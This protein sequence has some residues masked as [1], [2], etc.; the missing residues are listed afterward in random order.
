MPRQH[1]AALHRLI[2]E[3]AARLQRLEP[4][5]DGHPV[6]RFMQSTALRPVAARLTAEEMPR[7]LAACDA[8]LAEAC[9]AGPD[10]TVPFPFR[11]LSFVLTV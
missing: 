9:P 3:M 7:F 11:R 8:A 6:R 10:G 2:G 4:A 5:V 1:A